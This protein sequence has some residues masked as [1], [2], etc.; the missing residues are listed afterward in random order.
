MRDCAC[1][2][3]W[4]TIWHMNTVMSTLPMH[5]QSIAGSIHRFGRDGILYEVLRKVDDRSAIIRVIETGEETTYPI[6]EIQAD[7]TE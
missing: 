5:D 2:A 4:Y 3:Q 1:A 6:R 7:P